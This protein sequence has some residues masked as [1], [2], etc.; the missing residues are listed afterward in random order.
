MPS[1]MIEKSVA[2]NSTDP[3]ILSGSAYE[4]LRG[5]SLISLGVVASATGSFTTIQ[6]GADVVAEEFAT[7]IK[8]TYPLIPDEMYFNDVGV[9]GDRLVV[10][11]RNTTGGALTLRAVVNVA[12]AG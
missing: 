9:M 7:P 1:I 6:S 10:R 8:T 11:V 5:P 4:F 3:N 12:S 2:A